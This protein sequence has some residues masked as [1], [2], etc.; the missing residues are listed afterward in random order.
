MKIIEWEL[1]AQHEI[2][3]E[4]YHSGYRG[5]WPKLNISIGAS[6]QCPVC[7]H[8]QK[9]KTYEIH[10]MAD[11]DDIV[12]SAKEN[13]PILCRWLFETN[14]TCK[15]CGVASRVPANDC[16]ELERAI[17][18]R[19]TAE[20]IEDQFTKDDIPIMLTPSPWFREVREYD[21]SKARGSK[22]TA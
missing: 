6:V 5:S 14:W 16:G 21:A 11:E 12:F 13:V 4:G 22:V 17:K 10:V 7:K 9:V 2:S 3:A 15:S 18:A 8:L 1:R 19:C 20:W